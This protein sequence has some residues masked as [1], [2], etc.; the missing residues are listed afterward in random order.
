[1]CAWGC[2]YNTLLDKVDVVDSTAAILASKALVSS[3]SVFSRASTISF[4]SCILCS[5]MK[6]VIPFTPAAPK[7]TPLSIAYKYKEL[8]I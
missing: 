2:I 3:V 6:F 8:Q 1:M 5:C 7:L 4:T